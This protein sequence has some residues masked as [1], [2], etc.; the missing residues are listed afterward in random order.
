MLRMTV[1][2]LKRLYLAIAALEYHRRASY[3]VSTLRI[4][5]DAQLKDI[6]IKRHDIAR[7]AHAKCPQCHSDVWQEWLK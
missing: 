7:A 5:S 3:V 6:G 4:H 1:S 2:K